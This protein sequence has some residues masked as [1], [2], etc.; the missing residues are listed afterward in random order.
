MVEIVRYSS[1]KE[2]EWNDFVNNAKNG[3]FLFQRGYMDYHSDRFEDYSLMFFENGKLMALLPA[4]KKKGVLYSHQ[5]LTY[6]G[7]VLKNRITAKDVCAIFEELSNYLKSC[8]IEQVFYKVLPVIYA[9]L[10]SDEPIYSLTNVC[11]AEI[12]SRD[13]SSV[14]NLNNPLPFSELR[15]RGIKKATRHDIMIKRTEDLA[16]FWD[17]LV[18]NLKIKYD[19]KPVHSLAEIELLHRRFPENIQLWAAY[20]KKEIIGGTLLYVTSQVVKTQYI[21]ASPRGKEVCALDLLFDQL[22][23]KTSY[24]QS[25]FDLGTSAL[26]HSNN[27]RLPLLFQKEGF[28]ARAVCCDTYLW[29]LQYNN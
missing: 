4:N 24:S 7:L 26:E 23:N 28:G 10:P 25:F 8:K 5:G 29:N 18:Y 16:A 12:V 21:S 2:K 22:I 15:K 20:E 9:Q 19:S 11:K 1:E 17:I 3:T 6:G 14:I 27:L 13:I